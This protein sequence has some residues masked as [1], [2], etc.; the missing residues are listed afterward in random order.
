M[1]KEACGEPKIAQKYHEARRFDTEEKQA[2]ERQCDGNTEPCRPL[3]P[4]RG[5]DGGMP[6]TRFSL[7]A[8]ED[9][10]KHLNGSHLLL[11]PFRLLHLP[12]DVSGLLVVLAHHGRLPRHH[13]SIVHQR[14]TIS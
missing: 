14:Q 3:D 6:G 1:L 4:L 13:Q 5:S 11:P 7:F 8:D 12:A 9:E 10:A 2:R